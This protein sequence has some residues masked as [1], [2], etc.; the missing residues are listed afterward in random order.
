MRQAVLGIRG[1]SGYIC[2][3][4]RPVLPD[5]PLHSAVEVV[6]RVAVTSNHHLESRSLHGFRTAGVHDAL[7]SRSKCVKIGDR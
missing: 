6:S 3:E 7:R 2:H 4:F 1:P 5:R